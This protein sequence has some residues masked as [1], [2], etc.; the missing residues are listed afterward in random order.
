MYPKKIQVEGDFSN[1]L[2]ANYELEISAVTY[3]KEE[4]KDIHDKYSWSDYYV[5]QNTIINQLWWDAADIPIRDLE[6]QLGMKILTISSIRQPPGQ[7]IPIHKDIFHMIKLKYEMLGKL[8]RANI[9]LND[10][11]PGHMIQYEKDEEWFNW[12]N[13]KTNQGLLFDESSLHI[14][15]NGGTTHKYTLQLSGFLEGS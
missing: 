4:Q 9:H 7:V 6:K 11:A 15:M 12:T 10:W 5:D 1:I 14:G 8:V 3:D 2:N 13:W